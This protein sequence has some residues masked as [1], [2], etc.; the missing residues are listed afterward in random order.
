MKTTLVY[1]HPCGINTGADPEY[2]NLDVYDR[3]AERFVRTYKEFPAGCEHSLIVVL[4]NGLPRHPEI[5]DGLDV[6][7]LHYRGNGWCS[8]A[9]QYAAQRMDS[10]F[11]VFM[12]AR[13]HFWKEGWLKKFVIARV[14]FGE[15]FYGTMA[16]NEIRPHLRTNFYG[17]N[18]KTLIE[19]E[20]LLDCRESTWLIE[21][22]DLSMSRLAAARRETSLLV[23]WD[24]SFGM[25]A[26]RGP[27]NGFRRGNQSDCLVFDGHS[28]IF[29]KATPEERERLTALA[30]G[31]AGV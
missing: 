20:S 2:Q 22:G 21:S 24:A 10:E 29:E 3:A 9:H 19:Y 27:E 28:E 26:W 23:T 4:A 11:G 6:Q 7:F 31:K 25:S 1:L 8:G 5:Y 12:C 17:V 30:E 18:P 16:S 13:T 15:G 14:A